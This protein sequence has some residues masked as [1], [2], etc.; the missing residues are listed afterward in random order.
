MNKANI[1]RDKTK[2]H[3]KGESQRIHPKRVE[4]LRWLLRYGINK[5]DS[6]KVKTQV[7]I[8]HYQKQGGPNKQILC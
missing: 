1:D 7:L 8:Q 5:M 2:N 4:I 3:H 6:D